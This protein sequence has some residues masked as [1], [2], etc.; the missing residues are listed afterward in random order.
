MNKTT[1]RGLLRKGTYL[2][3]IIENTLQKYT[4]LRFGPTDMDTTLSVVLQ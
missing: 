3:Q 1:D 4:L 2:H